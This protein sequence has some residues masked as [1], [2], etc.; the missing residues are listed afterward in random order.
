MKCL[1]CNAPSEV[2]STRITKENNVK[3]IRLCFN[4]HKFSTLEQPSTPDKPAAHQQRASVS[5]AQSRRLGMLRQGRLLKAKAT[6][7]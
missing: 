2:K 5:E 1:T 6:G 7:G 4:Q 3:R